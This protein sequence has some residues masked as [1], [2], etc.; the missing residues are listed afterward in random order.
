MSTI[1]TLRIDNIGLFIDSI[2]ALSKVTEGIKFIVMS[3]SVSCYSRNDIARIIF[4]S[5]CARSLGEG[6]DFCIND[7]GKLLNFLKLLSTKEK[8]KSYDLLYNNSFLEFKG[9]LIKFK[10]M[11]VRE[12]IISTYIDKPISS[13]LTALCCFETSNSGIK[14]LLSN[15]S[16]ISSDLESIKYIIEQDTLKDKMVYATL[17]D[18]ENPLS[19][20][21]R[22]HFATVTSG[23][24]ETPV[25]L[26]TTRLQLANIIKSACIKF[27]ITNKNVIIIEIA[28]TRDDFSYNI[29]M[30]TSILRA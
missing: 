28:D 8:Q 16:L 26:N 15:K 24:F 4:K 21:L 12:D 25:L 20:S 9:S 29:T 6:F 3:N 13:E 14:E 23:K 1:Q 2:S 5:D 27:T 10:I 7:F 18:T 30:Y 19:N 11:T 17:Q 22:L